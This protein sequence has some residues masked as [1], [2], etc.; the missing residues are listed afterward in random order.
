MAVHIMN[1]L[2]DEVDGSS[3][4]DKVSLVEMQVKMQYFHTFGCPEYA[5][6]PEAESAMSK[7]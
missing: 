3:C 4:I 6:T 7:W 2:L 1:N 5:L